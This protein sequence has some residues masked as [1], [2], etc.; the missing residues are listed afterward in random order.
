VTGFKIK[1]R[2][3]INQS[4]S[5]LYGIDT[6]NRNWDGVYIGEGTNAGITG[7]KSIDDVDTENHALFA[8][9]ETQLT[10]THIKVG[11]RVDD[12]SIDTM[13]AGLSDNDYK[14]ISGH[15][16]AKH[17]VDDQRAYFA[18]FGRSSRVPDARELY[19]RNRM[20]HL[21]GTPTLND[22]R[23]YEFD[24]GVENSYES[25]NL[26][27]KLFYS[28]LKDYIYFNADKAAV[29]AP[30][31][32]A[33]ENI[34][35]TIYGL[36]LSGTYFISD[37]MFVDFGMAYLKGEKDEA[38]AGQTDKDL[39]EI[40]PLKANLALN[41]EYGHNNMAT[42]EVVAA[43]AWDSYDMDNG[44]QAIS[45]YGVTN[46]KLTHNASNDFEVTVGVDNVFDKTYAVSNTYNDLTLLSAGGVVM[47][48]NEPG[49]YYYLNAAY[50]F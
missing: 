16:F 43:D 10:D 23:N 3:A 28:W 7:N 48:L 49:R 15:V 47:L 11:L 18:G 17:Q 35:A 46:L 39:A 41:Y 44:E 6:S 13:D 2:V 50:K 20:G 8:E 37:A 34:D 22:T 12:T 40:P 29:M 36:E 32:N 45:G 19:F 1:N 5:L 31:R 14:S 9:L 25:F 33:F 27:T 24:F 4:A 42:L 30:V 26:K 38:L 21:I